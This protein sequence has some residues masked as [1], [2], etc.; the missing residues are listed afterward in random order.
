MI[1]VTPGP[2]WP[3]YTI[4]QTRTLENLANRSLPVNTLMQRA[5]AACAR[6]ALAIAPHAHITWIACGP[7]N[8][9][10]DG[11]ETAVQLARLGKFTAV[12]WLGDPAHLPPD[13][14]LAHQRAMAAG[15]QFVT[16]APADCDLCVDALL[17]IG[18]V[19]RQPPLQMIA[20]ID[21]L[22]AM[23]CPVLAID[24]PSGLDADTGSAPYASVH[25]S[26]TLSLLTLKPG[27]FM[28]AGRDASGEI[29]FDDLGASDPNAP[30]CARL[31]ATPVP[32][33]R[34]HQSHKGSFGDLA[35][36]GGAKGMT[37]AAVLAASAALHGGAGRVF[38]C[39]LDESTPPIN[40]SQ[41]E[42][43][44]RPSHGLDF[45]RMTL[46]CGC[47][48]G[49]ALNPQLETL[50]TTAA[51]LV[52]DADGLNALAGDAPL[53]DLL[54]RRADK[55]APTVLTP[56]P[57]EAARLLGC[58]TAD[59]QANRLAAAQTLAKKT[60]CVVVLKGSGTVIA[61][62]DG[63]MFINPTG[64]GRLATAGTGDVLAGMVGAG[65]AGGLKA[66]DAAC[67]SVY[68]HGMIAD[69][70]PADRPLT[71]SALAHLGHER[72]IA[73]SGQHTVGD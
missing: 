34:C 29:W 14:A 9:G 21:Q 3:L 70:W 2:A 8:N 24:V 40:M 41:P 59:V 53:L 25:A 16:A 31:L 27:L 58:S 4:A 48:A 71:A 54:K 32:N 67:H 26:H 18:G 36:V 15:V 35:V 5:G 49:D 11:L 12:T 65:M 68:Q 60:G 13:S 28:G 69:Q 52:I 6:L 42:L 44:F 33:K 45:S 51:G 63:Q 64:N 17:G 10:G 19:A 61:G 62:T 7:G 50:I 56:H 20:L 30:P 73:Q 46:V 38:V 22:N 39:L 43:M 1:R 57:L 37:G 55:L 72:A 23:Q 66:F 47:G